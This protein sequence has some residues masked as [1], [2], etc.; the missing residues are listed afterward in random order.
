[1]TSQTISLTVHSKT[2]NTWIKV[3]EGHKH[4]FDWAIILK[5]QRSI[6]YS[7]A[8]WRSPCPCP[9]VCTCPQKRTSSTNC[10]YLKL[11]G[12]WS[13]Q[14]VKSGGQTHTIC[15]SSNCL[16]LFFHLFLAFNIKN[17]PSYT[18]FILVQ[19]CTYSRLHTQKKRNK[20]P[21]E[22]YIA[23]NLFVLFVFSLVFYFP[24]IILYILSMYFSILK[25]KTVNKIFL[26][27]KC[28]FLYMY[29]TEYNMLPFI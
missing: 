15:L 1:M 13:G 21:V 9:P 3:W 26:K 19:H 27:G 6:S 5:S 10:L 11:L 12:D 22:V 18:L 24:C 28:I 20:T 2:L 25:F 7:A 16:C 4:H 23:F 8:W 29:G 17:S 14:T